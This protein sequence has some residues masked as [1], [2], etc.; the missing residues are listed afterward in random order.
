MDTN[1]R[2]RVGVLVAAFIVIAFIAIGFVHVTT[3]I[4]TGTKIDFP[5]DWN[6]AMLSLA[7]AALGFLIGKQTTSS[8]T[9]VTVTTDPSSAPLRTT[10][11]PPGQT[12]PVAKDT[13]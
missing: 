3:Y 12:S 8:S 10:E 11:I 1:P 2:E 4:V 7:S 5:P 13:P 6:A 9:P